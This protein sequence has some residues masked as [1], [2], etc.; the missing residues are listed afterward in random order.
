[1]TAR[2]A[3]FLVVSLLSRGVDA[4]EQT[5][6][7]FRSQVRR[8]LVDVFVTESGR[9]VAG[10]EAEDFHV[11]DNGALQTN[12]SLV[13]ASDLPL[14]ATLLLDTSRSVRGEKLID[15]RA[16]AAAFIDELHDPDT[17][18]IATF[19]THFRVTRAFTSDH[20]AAKASLVELRASGATALLDSIL[21]SLVYGD[22]LGRRLVVVF[23]D[24]LDTASW[25]SPEDLIASA[26]RSDAV[27]FA[28]RAGTREDAHSGAES[29]DPDP[30]DRVGELALQNVVGAT[31]G[32]VVTVR[33]DGTVE[34]AF[35]SVLN[36]MRSRYLLTYEPSETEEGWH[37]LTVRLAGEQGHDVRARKGYYSTIGPER[38]HGSSHPPSQPHP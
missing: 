24:G 2:W 11:F 20:A 17:V 18:A 10:L 12:V 28:V 5:G 33:E 23:S 32:R 22:E 36:E 4:Q 16:A 27:L 7:T 8:V 1:M 15:L 37:E 9:P 29:E 6:I 14:A 3:C 26:E 19:G 34:K 35:K 13:V 31:A 25:L 38:R 30:M 21:F